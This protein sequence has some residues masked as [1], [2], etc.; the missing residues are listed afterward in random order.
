MD[1]QLAALSRRFTEGERWFTT[2]P[3]Y[4]YLCLLIAADERLLELAAACRSGQYPPNLF[5]AAVHYLVLLHRDNELASW[6][7]SVVGEDARAPDTVAPAFRS[8]CEEYRPDL[9]ELVR[10]RLVQTNVV[11]RAGAVRLGLAVIAREFEAQV[12]LMEIGASAGVLLLFDR[13]RY[14]IRGRVFGDP[15]STVTI[16]PQ[17]RG[18]VQLPNFDH[19]PRIISRV[20][21]DLEPVDPANPDQRR[22]LEALV[23]PENRDEAALLEAALGIVQRNPPRIVAGNAIEVLPRLNDELPALQPLVIL[24][25]ATRAHVPKAERAAFDNAIEELARRRTVFRLAIEGTREPDS[26]LDEPPPFHMLT[27]QR[28]SAIGHETRAIAGVDGHA[29]WIHALDV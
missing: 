18:M 25:S 7:P 29:R 28:L 23:W 13:Y 12:H 17:W 27:L 3:L 16:R 20:G 8:F 10:R 1:R 22:W 19:V 21:V 9:L 5:L 24:H 14:E 26:R 11:A 2:S 4:R 6:Y 15:A